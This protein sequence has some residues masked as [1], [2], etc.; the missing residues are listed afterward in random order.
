VR[1][2]YDVTVVK[3]AEPK[4]HDVAVVPAASGSTTA[5]APATATATA[6][7]AA[8]AP[9]AAAPALGGDISPPPGVGSRLGGD[10]TPPTSESTTPTPRPPAEA[11]ALPVLFPAAPASTAAPTA[12]P[13]VQSPVPAPG[14][15]AASTLPASAAERWAAAAAA[16]RQPAPT[17]E[18]AAAGAAPSGQPGVNLSLKGTSKWSVRDAAGNRYSTLQF[19]RLVGDR[20]TL[21]KL[22]NERVLAKTGQI[23]VAV[24]AGGL[25]LASLVVATGNFGEPAITDYSVDPTPY[26]TE[27]EY[28][29]ATAFARDQYDRAVSSWQEQRL[30][31]A[32]FLGGSGAIAFAVMPFVG[33]DQDRREDLPNVVYTREEATRLVDAYNVANPPSAGAVAPDGPV[34]APAVVPDAAPPP[35][36]APGA[37]PAASAPAPAAPAPAEPA[38]AAPP[39]IVQPLFGVGFFGIQGTF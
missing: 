1:V 30:G 6:P 7:A 8:T 19:A 27:E 21:Q 9:T 5:T 37:A 18:P 38:G 29:A 17:P 35:E 2:I 10:I 32:L 13:L 39:V 16:A 25:L 11:P 23:G 24:A 3:K 28:D 20:E 14:E 33:K 22:E 36:A 26:E 4:I 12:D 34:L 31:T 15:P